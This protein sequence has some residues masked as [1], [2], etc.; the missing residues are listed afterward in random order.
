LKQS[1]SHAPEL[2][3]FIDELQLKST[4]L[5]KSKKIKQWLQWMQVPILQMEK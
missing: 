3:V 1:W 5:K 4:S 2:K